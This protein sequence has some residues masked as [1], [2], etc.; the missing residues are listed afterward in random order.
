VAVGTP[1]TSIVVP[2]YNERENIETLVP[3]LQEILRGVG[4]EILVV[5]DSSPDGT[6]DVVRSFAATDS[7]VR[8]VTRERKTGL[9][10]AVFAGVAA[11]TGTYVCVMD[12]DLS[13]DPEEVPDMLRLARAENADV[14]I[15]SRYVKGSS[16]V[17]QPLWRQGASFVLNNATRLLLWLRPRDVLTGYVVCKREVL[18]N[19]PTHYSSTGFK[20]LVEVLSTQPGLRV[21]EWPIVFHDRRKGYSKATVREMFELARLCLRL[22]AW[23]V[24][25]LRRLG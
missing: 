21:R 11:A 13:H 5:D 7:R 2:T 20:F 14:V 10:G 8:L 3:R 25:H 9:A 12:A 18:A 15:G 19:N 24:T 6:G 1:L 16:F 23:R 22:I 4:A 17:G